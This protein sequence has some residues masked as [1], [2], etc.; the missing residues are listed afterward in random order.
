MLPITEQEN[1]ATIYTIHAMPTLR[2][3]GFQYR[4]EAT[5]AH[6]NGSDYTGGN[7]YKSNIDGF[8]VSN[9]IKVQYSFGFDTNYKYADHN[10][11]G[12]IFQLLAN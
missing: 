4:N 7:I 10:P 12:I 9:N 3:A 5:Q 1:G 2:N 6:L 11:V 8:L